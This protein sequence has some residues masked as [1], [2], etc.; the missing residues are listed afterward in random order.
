MSSG[1]KMK[2]NQH[3]NDLAISQVYDIR[4]VSLLQYKEVEILYTW[5]DIRHNFSSVLVNCHWERK[6]TPE[7]NNL[8]LIT[9]AVYTLSCKI[10][11]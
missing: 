1:E 3:K 6:I 2:K 4:N 10:T 5:L 9:S 11:Q 8:Q 7:V